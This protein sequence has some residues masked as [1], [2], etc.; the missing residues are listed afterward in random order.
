MLMRKT[1]YTS[2]VV[3]G[4]CVMTGCNTSTTGGTPGA[5]GFKLKGPSNVTAT[6]IKHDSEKTEKITVDADKAFKEEIT[7]KADVNPADKGVTA[8]VEPTT[9]KADAPREVQLHIK[10]SDK[11]A[12]GEYTITVTGKPAKG[13]ET[14]VTVKVKVPEKK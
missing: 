10:A 7:F 3:A 13:N 9:L 1:I 2:L 11:A 5:G 8:K 12:P 14:N 4:L 6:E